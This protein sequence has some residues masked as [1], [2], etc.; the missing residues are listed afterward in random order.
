MS[1][2]DYAITTKSPYE[3]LGFPSATAL[4]V[5]VQAARITGKITASL[6]HRIPHVLEWD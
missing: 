5:N 3:V 4:D 6:L 1:I 2:E